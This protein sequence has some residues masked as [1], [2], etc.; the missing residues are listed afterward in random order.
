MG[1]KEGPVALGE[2]DG[3]DGVEWV[4]G[5]VEEGV[6]WEDMWRVVGAAIWV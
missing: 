3:W 5:G 4:L 1:W 6:G 2:A